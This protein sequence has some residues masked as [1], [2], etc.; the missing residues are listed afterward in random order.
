MGHR[1][2]GIT[3]LGILYIILG[4][5]FLLG[6]AFFGVLSASFMQSSVLSGFGAIGGFIAIFMIIAAIIEFVIAGALF[7]G[8]SWGRTIVMIFAILDI[9]FQGGSL[10][11]GN[12]GGVLAIILD[13]IVLYYMWRPHVIRYFKGT[14][15][16]N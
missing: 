3:I 11:V 12:V 1:P 10:L 5:G 6:A 7:S 14:E 4:I 8:K 2:T 9:I 13:L 16:E 15:Y